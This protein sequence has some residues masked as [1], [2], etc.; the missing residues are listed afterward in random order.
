M[1]EELAAFEDTLLEKFDKKRNP[2]IREVY[3][4][5]SYNIVDYDDIA[6]TIYSFEVFFVVYLLYGFINEFHRDIVNFILDNL[7]KDQLLLIIARIPVV[8]RSLSNDKIKTIQKN[9]KKIKFRSSGYHPFKLSAEKIKRKSL[10]IRSPDEDYHRKYDVYTL[11]QHYMF[12]EWIK[13]IKTN[14]D[15][16]II[17]DDIKFYKEPEPVHKNHYYENRYDIDKV[18]GDL[19]RLLMDTYVGDTDLPIT[20]DMLATFNNCGHNIVIAMLIIKHRGVLTTHVNLFI[21]D[22]RNKRV[23]RFEPKGEDIEND[24]EIEKSLKLYKEFKHYTYVNTSAVCPIGIQYIQEAM[25]HGSKIPREASSSEFGY[26]FVWSLLFGHYCLHFPDYTPEEVSTWLFN[27]G[28]ILERVRE[29]SGWL[30]KMYEE[31]DEE[32][33]TPLENPFDKFMD[34]IYLGSFLI[35]DAYHFHLTKEVIGRGYMTP[36]EFINFYFGENSPMIDNVFATKIF[37]ESLFLPKDD[38]YSFNHIVDAFY[39]PLID[40]LKF[41]SVIKQAINRYKSMGDIIFDHTLTDN[42]IRDD[43]DPEFLIWLAK[44]TH[45]ERVDQLMTIFNHYYA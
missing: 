18:E 12:M 6:T 16:C 34:Y 2:E 27:R 19:R 15:A 41:K 33:Y 3:D 20:R 40:P 36:E 22:K 8:Y 23:Y 5:F 32:T 39:L 26:C 29:Y 35:F 28:N 11:T 17:E 10:G 7:S 44:P 30:V 38:E 42:Y 21:F 43:L 45:K 4:K 1:E 13:Y 37:I 9:F 25:Y 24:Q 31:A 14:Y